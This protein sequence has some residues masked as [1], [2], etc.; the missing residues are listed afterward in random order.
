[1]LQ[2]VQALCSPVPDRSGQPP[3]RFPSGVDRQRLALLLA[4]LGKHTDLRPY[5]FD[6]YLNVT[7][8]GSCACLLPVAVALAPA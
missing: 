6:V 7:G 5:S 4:V 3:A 8:G 1:M 2:E